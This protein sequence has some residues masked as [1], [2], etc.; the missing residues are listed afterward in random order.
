MLKYAAACAM[1]A[2]LVGAVALALAAFWHGYKVEIGKEGSPVYIMWEQYP[3]RRFFIDK[4]E[5]K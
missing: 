2:T 4:P 5:E 1:Y 3:L